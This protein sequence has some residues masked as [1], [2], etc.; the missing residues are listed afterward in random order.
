MQEWRLCAF[1]LS[2]NVEWF[3]TAIA[4]G[5]DM[6]E[7]LKLSP[8]LNTRTD[9]YV[10]C[11]S[12][13]H[14]FRK[15]EQLCCFVSITLAYILL[16]LYQQTVPKPGYRL[17][18]FSHYLHFS[19]PPIKLCTVSQRN[20]PLSYI[21]CW[22]LVTLYDCLHHWVAL[23]IFQKQLWNYYFSISTLHKNQFTTVHSKIFYQNIV[24]TVVYQL[25][26]KSL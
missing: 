15:L 6:H 1:H 2:L 8:G 17:K 16:V 14:L 13:S 20:K 7:S 11:M 12:W 9:W 4:M 23:F 5:R 3:L 25:M 10:L 26:H 21:L 22:W 24:D 19:R 18:E